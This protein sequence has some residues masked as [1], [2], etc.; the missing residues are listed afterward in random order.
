[1]KVHGKHQ[2]YSE[3]YLGSVERT[4]SREKL[5]Y[6][7]DH[8]TLPTRLRGEAYGVGAMLIGVEGGGIRI[9]G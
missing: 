6:F 4:G 9:T 5:F 3:S 1:M 2:T 7:P 8:H